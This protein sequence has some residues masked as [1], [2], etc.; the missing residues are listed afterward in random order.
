MS[1]GGEEGEGEVGRRRTQEREVKGIGKWGK[2]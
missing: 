1:V 2:G